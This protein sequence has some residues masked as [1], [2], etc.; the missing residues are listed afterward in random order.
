MSCCRTICSAWRYR[1]SSDATAPA[2]DRHNNVPP[3]TTKGWPGS[4]PTANRW[5]SP[6]SALTDDGLTSQPTT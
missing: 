3:T 2:A 1:T 4:Q 6:V 5:R